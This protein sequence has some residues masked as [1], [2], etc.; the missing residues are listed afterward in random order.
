MD[1]LRISRRRSLDQKA[2]RIGGPLLIF[3]LDIFDFFSSAIR[4]PSVRVRARNSRT[5]TGR[6]ERHKGYFDVCNIGC[7]KWTG[8]DDVPAHRRQRHWNVGDGIRTRDLRIPQE[9]RGQFTTETL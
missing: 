1:G 2:L 9:R 7:D 3:R 4:F 6:P 5:F 8:C